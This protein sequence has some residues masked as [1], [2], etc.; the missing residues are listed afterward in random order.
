MH[1][2]AIHYSS[3]VPPTGN[4]REAFGLQ[5]AIGG[6][7]H[8]WLRYTKEERIRFLI[9]ETAEFEQIRDAVKAANIPGARVEIL[10][11]RFPDRNYRDIGVIFRAEPDTRNLLWQRNT[12]GGFSFCGLAHAISGVEAGEVLREYC[13]APSDSADALICPSHAVKSAIRSFF[14]HYDAFISERYNTRYACPV[15]LPVIPLGIDVDKIAAKATPEKRKD[16]REKLGIAQ[17]ETVLLWV[18]RLSAAIKAHPLAMFRAAEM[19]ARKTG[20]KVHLVMVG[21]FVPTEAEPG[22]RKLAASICAK[23]KVTFVPADDRRF[24]DGLWAAG[25]IFLSLV[26]NMQ[27]SFG[28]T[29]LE[30]MAAGLPR[31]ISDWDGY[32]D[33]VTDGEDGFL[34]PTALPPP[35]MGAELVTQVMNGV[36]LYGGFLAKAALTTYVDAEAA[37]DHIARLMTDPDLRNSMIA[38]AQARV[39]AIYDWRHIIPRQEELWQELAAMRASMPASKLSLSSPLPQLPDPYVMYQAY[40]TATLNE[41]IR[42]QVSADLDQIKALWTHELNVYANDVLIPPHEASRI[43]GWLGSAGVVSIGDLMR[44]FPEWETPRLW[45]MVAWFLKLGIIKKMP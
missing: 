16:Q 38:K 41:D 45:R 19:A 31:V 32:R 13:I 40:P 25:D 18:G 27:E 8:A 14:D 1:S 35:A 5:V 24:P 36:E 39:R 21:Y 42:V 10:D 37:A 6:W 43:V 12:Y 20:A 23:A 4:V 17:D 34:V 2:V 28:L 7:L 33:S 3:V 26:D 11:R 29:P 15:H 22:F 30:A 9:G 44:Q